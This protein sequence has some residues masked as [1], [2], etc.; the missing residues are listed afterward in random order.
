MR[1]NYAT[2][3]LSAVSRRSRHP[4]SRGGKCLFLA[5]TGAERAN[6]ELFGLLKEKEVKELELRHRTASVRLFG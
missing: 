6:P 1:P 3:P 5:W 2:L 4:R